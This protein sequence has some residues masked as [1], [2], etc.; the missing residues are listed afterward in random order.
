MKIEQYQGCNC[1]I[2]IEPEEYLVTTIKLKD[3]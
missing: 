3:C 2:T 1:P